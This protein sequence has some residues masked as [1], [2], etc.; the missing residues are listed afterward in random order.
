[1]DG[2]SLPGDELVLDQKIPLYDRVGM[3][4]D[5]EGIEGKTPYGTERT[6]RTQP[7]KKRVALFSAKVLDTQLALADRVEPEYLICFWI[8][9]IDD[10]F[11]GFSDNPGQTRTVLRRVGADLFHISSEIHNGA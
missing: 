9:D 2:P 10:V 1:M 11:H 6:G 4:P 5:I 7:L 8:A 3:F